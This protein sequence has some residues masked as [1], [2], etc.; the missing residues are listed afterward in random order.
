VLKFNLVGCICA[1]RVLHVR[2]AA[3]LSFPF[4][5]AKGKNDSQT[6][7]FKKKQFHNQETKSAKHF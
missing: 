7:A 2:Q 5:C 4:A 1:S 3:S 6:S